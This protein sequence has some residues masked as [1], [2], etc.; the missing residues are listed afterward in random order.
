MQASGRA[1]AIPFSSRAAELYGVLAGEVGSCDEYG[2]MLAEFSRVLCLADRAYI[3]SLFN[4][5]H[6]AV[7]KVAAALDRWDAEDTPSYSAAEELA[8]TSEPWI[9]AVLFLTD[10]TQSVKLAQNRDRYTL[11]T[12][13]RALDLLTQEE[14]E[15]ETASELSGMTL[16]RVLIAKAKLGRDGLHDTSLSA[17]ASARG[18]YC[19]SLML[20]LAPFYKHMELLDR[21]LLPLLTSALD[22]EQADQGSLLATQ[23]ERK[24]HLIHFGGRGSALEA[25]DRALREA[26]S[27]GR[28]VL[29]VAPES[30]GKSALLARTSDLLRPTTCLGDCNAQVNSD[31]APWLPGV[32]F[33]SGKQVADAQQAVRLT[34]A[35][36]NVLLA[37]PTQQPRIEPVGS[38]NRFAIPDDASGRSGVGSGAGFGGVASGRSSGAQTLRSALTANWNRVSEERSFT[39]VI[40]DGLDE[41]EPLAQRWD[42]LPETPPPG[43]GA[44]LSVRQGTP[45]HDWVASHRPVTVLSL[46]ALGESDIAEILGIEVG[47]TGVNALVRKVLR[48][49]KGFPLLVVD[50]AQQVRNLG[51]GLDERA[52]RIL[53]RRAQVFEEWASRW[54]STSGPGESDPSQL[55]LWLLAVFEPVKPLELGDVQRFLD[56]RGIAMSLP[57]IRRMLAPV[58]TQARGMAGS[59]LKLNVEAFGEYVCSQ[60]LSQR[61]L[62]EF[63]A[64]VAH[65]LLQDKDASASTLAGFLRTWVGDSRRNTMC[66]G[67]DVLEMVE[68]NCGPERLQDVAQVLWALDEDSDLAPRLLEWAAASG[69]PS[70]LGE[71]GSRSLDGMGVPKDTD[72]GLRLLNEAIEAGE[73]QAVGE[74][75]IRLVR[76]TGVDAVPSRGAAMLEDAIAK[77]DLSACLNLGVELVL[78]DRLDK[79]IVRGRSLLERA[80]QEESGV[81]ATATWVLGSWLM[82]GQYLP[83][84][85]RLGVELLKQ[86]AEQGSVPAMYELG[87][88]LRRGAGTPQNLDAARRWLERSSAA[89]D[90]KSMCSLGKLLIDSVPF[91]GAVSRGIEW[92]EQ[93]GEQDPA[94]A[95]ELGR[96]RLLGLGMPIDLE[97][98]LACLE[99]AAERGC[100][101]AMAMFGEELVSGVRLPKDAERGLRFLEDAV[102]SGETAALMRFVRVLLAGSGIPPD[103]DRAVALLDA[104]AGKGDAA[105]MTALA[106]LLLAGECGPDDAKKARE[107]L[108]SAAALGYTEAFTRLGRAI[109]KGA[110]TPREPDECR[111]VLQK[112]AAGGDPEAMTE[113]AA[114]ALSE[115]TDDDAREA[116]LGLLRSAIDAGDTGALLTMGYELYALGLHERAA[117]AFLEGFRAGVHFCGNNL[118]YMVRRDEVAVRPEFPHIDQLLS[119]D[120]D[121]AFSVVNQCLSKAVGTAADPAWRKADSRM[122]ALSRRELDEVGSWWGPLAREG[123]AEGHL[124][125]AWLLR[126]GVTTDAGL[127]TLA[128]HLDSARAGGWLVP[129]W[130]G[131]APRPL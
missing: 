11:F 13:V 97:L 6:N 21:C 67:S 36:A 50:V 81:G 102:E 114:L 53:E 131:E 91:E 109:R 20:I 89:G 41:I 100:P 34:I 22:V 12:C 9:K 42:F 40:I 129:S 77:C 7:A 27:S 68:M 32:V 52:I 121:T 117:S 126:G 19:A 108:D 35:Q 4:P 92:L 94:A 46:T 61:D 111:D 2:G 82:G 30:M 130:M 76:G 99:D 8:R 3:A 120:A 37:N 112:G 123:D 80:M 57:D 58:G 64:S 124:V 106:D 71:L 1:N 31:L 33:V 110:L 73:T 54:T 103:E 72:R 62:S 93:A 23:D 122:A 24:L 98:G 85:E 105:A 107:M 49:T 88:R 127:T 59:R 63:V 84:D 18:L 90:P 118:A 38:S 15:R 125:C 128:E 44:L 51:T 65:W 79:D 70:A 78:G 69:L 75:G 55:V 104:A 74:L 17:S 60:H 29:L 43:V 87:D 113:L 28:Y 5:A 115:A 26:A 47:E 96:R 10:P 119:F 56:C 116:A 25:V 66:K 39:P 45:A 83:I 86:A 14:L 16:G 101:S 95:F 48:D